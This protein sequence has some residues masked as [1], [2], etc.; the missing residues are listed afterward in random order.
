MKKILVALD[1]SE[2]ANK[3]LMEAK[4]LGMAFNSDITLL[5]VIEDLANPDAFSVNYTIGNAVTIQNELREQSGKLLDE[6]MEN[7]KDYKGQVN[8]MTKRGKP[9]NTIL[10]VAEEGNYDLVVL[11]SRGLGVF[12][13][14]MLGSVSNKVV[15]KV[16]SSVLIVK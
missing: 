15:H 8:T 2:N 4:Q 10:E 11:G 5:H 12:A 3:S 1:G 13:G 16:K 6:Y 9:G 14:T 7:F